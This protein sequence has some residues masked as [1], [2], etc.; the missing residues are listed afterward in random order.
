MDTPLE[1]SL[2]AQ[3]SNGGVF[4]FVS[5]VEIEPCWKPSATTLTAA[6]A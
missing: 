2:V 3:P 6:L 5:E 4:R 1:R